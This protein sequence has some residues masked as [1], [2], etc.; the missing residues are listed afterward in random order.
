MVELLS[1]RIISSSKIAHKQMQILA[2]L[3]F[4]SDL[5]AALA[6]DIPQTAFPLRE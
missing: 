4:P 1:K 6:R 5:Y 3:G 2:L